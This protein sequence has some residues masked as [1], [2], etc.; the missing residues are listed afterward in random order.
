MNATCFPSGYFVLIVTYQVYF[1][2]LRGGISLLGIDFA[3]ISIAQSSVAAHRKET[4]RMGLET[5]HGID[6]LW[7]IERERIY[8][9]TSPVTFAQ[10]IDSLIVR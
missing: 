4:N 6:G 3:I 1:Y 5:C 10:E 9:E 7:G 2:F 8:I